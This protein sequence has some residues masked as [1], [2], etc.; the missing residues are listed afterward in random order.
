MNR[1]QLLYKIFKNSFKYP[2]FLKFS[3]GYVG[4]HA[5]GFKDFMLKPELIRSISEAGFENPSE[6]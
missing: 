6:G 1:N 5:T 3:R 4:I 2:L